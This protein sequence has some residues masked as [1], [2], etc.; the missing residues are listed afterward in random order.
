ML[1]ELARLEY[2]SDP[3]LEDLDALRLPALGALHDVELNLLTFLEGAEA[4]ALDGG[5]MHKNIL[6]IRPAEKPK[7]LAIVEP[8]HC[9]LF[10]I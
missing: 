6:A 8:L 4:I 5:V 2:C 1:A 9:S 10:H 3:V 7:T